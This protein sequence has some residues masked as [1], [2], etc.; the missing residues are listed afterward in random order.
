M[1][2]TFSSLYRFSFLFFSLC[3]YAIYAVTVAGCMELRSM[4]LGI[5][6]ACQISSCFVLYG[7][8]LC[9]FEFPH[10]SPIVY[11]V[12]TNISMKTGPT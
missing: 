3:C 7:A 9:G 11:T 12:N 6:M 8:A 5:S 1:S 2:R 10:K 4:H